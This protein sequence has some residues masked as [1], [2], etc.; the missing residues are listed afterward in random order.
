MYPDGYTYVT[1]GDDTMGQTDNI[2]IKTFGVYPNEQFIITA[3]ARKYFEGNESQAIRFIIREYARLTQN[4]NGK[5]V[6]KAQ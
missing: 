2:S 6:E 1:Y 4:G 3:I 5:D